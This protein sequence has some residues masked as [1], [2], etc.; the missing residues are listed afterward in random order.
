MDDQHDKLETPQETV[1][2][3][4]VRCGD[5]F[6][7]RNQRAP[8]FAKVCS[9]MGI[10]DAGRPCQYFLPNVRLFEITSDDG[11][12]IAEIISKIP[13]AHLARW[14]DLL[15]REAKTRRYGFH[16]GEQ[17]YIR[18]F[19]EDYLS[20]Y[21]SGKVVYADRRRIF[22]EV[23]QPNGRGF[24]G[25]FTPRSVLDVADFAIKRKELVRTK[26]LI[27]PS[28]KKYTSWRPKS[29]LDINYE[30]PTINEA[31]DERIAAIKKRRKIKQRDT[32]THIF[33]MRD[34]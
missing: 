10:T 32:G 33:S 21:F 28:I 9:E 16:M 31:I 29:K 15:V 17:V 11:K 8:K 26:R 22:V 27:D 20:N 30:P 4:P 13:K 7:L 34:N 6:Y 18:I 14:G 12:N 25:Q 19:P 3:I 23:Q 2:T 1:I 24:R 5:C